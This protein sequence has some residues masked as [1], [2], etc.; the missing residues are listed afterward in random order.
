[1]SFLKGWRTYIIFG[2]VLLASLADLLIANGDF[3]KQYLN[4]DTTQVTA[5]LSALAVFMRSIT[6][7]K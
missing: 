7:D 4:F 1:M 5:A 6:G 2:A 3:I